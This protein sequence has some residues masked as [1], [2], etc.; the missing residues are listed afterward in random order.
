MSNKGKHINYNPKSLLN[1]TSKYG[2][3]KGKPAYWKGKIGRRAWNKG[4]K[5]TEE[6]KKKISESLKG[7]TSWNKGKRYPQITGE[8]HPL[9]NGGVT[10]VVKLIR[11][12][13][14]YKQWRSD[15]F[16]R[17][18]WTCKTCGKNGGN[19]SVHHIKSFHSIIVDNNILS[20]EDAIKCNELWDTNN[21][22]TL[23][24]ECHS[25]TDNYKFKSKL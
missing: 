9:W 12:L 8:K 25:L 17:D 22:V 6:T 19:L 5:L 18:N 16:Q 23:C 1:L 21:G 24:E 15:V 4:L 7:K 11:C 20:C 14:E 3:Q 13:P 2:F 10:K